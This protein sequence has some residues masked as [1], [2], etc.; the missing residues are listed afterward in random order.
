[1]R[2]FLKTGSMFAVA[3]G[4][5]GVGK[6]IAYGIAAA[7]PS[8]A[9]IVDAE[10]QREPM[11][12]IRTAMFTYFPAEAME[13]R[14]AMIRA[15]DRGR[16]DDAARARLESELRAVMA[17]VSGLMAL[18]T[19]AEV[20][21]LIDAKINLFTRL[22]PD[23]LAC[24]QAV[25]G[26]VTGDLIAHPLLADYDAGADYALLYRTLS[27][28]RYRSL[29]PVAASDEDYETFGALLAATSLQDEDFDALDTLD[30]S[31]PRLCGAT[32]TT[33]QVLRDAD[34]PGAAAVRREMMLDMI[35]G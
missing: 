31:S 21:P 28:A 35:S 23:P 15:V 6:S 11:R 27:Q 8:A 26:G 34:F 1:M 18:A 13:V 24:G 20:R 4:V 7:R 32:I 29:A 22:A 12:T 5:Y 3:L 2:K 19:D 16:M 14:A 33:L 25:V 9:E 10:L 30:P 17:P